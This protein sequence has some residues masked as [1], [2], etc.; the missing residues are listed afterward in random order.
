MSAKYQKRKEANKEAYKGKFNA[1]ENAFSDFKNDTASRFYSQ[2]DLV[3]DLK[4]MSD[5][6]N[7]ETAELET[8]EAIRFALDDMQNIID[9]M[10]NNLI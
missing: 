6:C 3:Q 1:L 4:E 9:E 5:D 7:N 8:L 10:K 2:K